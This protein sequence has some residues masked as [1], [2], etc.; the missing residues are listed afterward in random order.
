[1]RRRPGCDALLAAALL[2]ATPSIAA[3]D[4]APE[5]DVVH[6][7]APV[8][9]EARK[10]G[11]VRLVTRGETTVVQTV[12]ATRVLTRVVAE[13]RAKDE[14]N[15]PPESAGHDDMKRYVAALENAAASL[16]AALPPVDARTTDDPER[17]IPFLIEFRADAKSAEVAIGTFQQ[18][19]ASSPYEI[20]SAR[21]LGTPSA[22]RA[23]VLENMRLILVDSFHVSKDEIAKLGPLGPL[24]AQ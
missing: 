15:W 4:V 14:A 23:Y 13:I 3:T 16:R 9:D 5:R 24:A 2:V 10:I 19:D 8:P 18:R 1:M 22:S 21:T 7:R 11:E 20:A 12:I 17:R 6:A